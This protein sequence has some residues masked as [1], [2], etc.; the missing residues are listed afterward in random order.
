[1]KK[2]IIGLSLFLAGIL[3]LT[4]CGCSTGS[5]GGGGGGTADS[6]K[7][8]A[9]TEDKMGEGILDDGGDINVSDPVQVAVDVKVEGEHRIYYGKPEDEDKVEQHNSVLGRWNSD[10]FFR[11]NGPAYP[12]NSHPEITREEV[13]DTYTIV[14]LDISGFADVSNVGLRVNLINIRASTLISVSTDKQHWT[15]IGYP[16]ETFNGIR[17]DYTT[18]LDELY[19]WQTDENIVDGVKSD[20]NI[21]ACYYL[22]G[23]YAKKGQPIYIKC[24]WSD[25]YWQGLAGKGQPCDLIAYM[26]YYEKMEIIYDY[27]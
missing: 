18:H 10:R 8:V 6:G 19:S 3:G 20:A 1:M 24:G 17:G 5:G 9:D 15:D 11:I 4:I 2:H 22:L 21:F 23:E 16:D 12:D 13:E 27:I 14:T 7:H 25:A 26:S